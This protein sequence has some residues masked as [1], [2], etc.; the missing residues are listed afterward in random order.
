MAAWPI[1]HRCVVHGIKR[2]KRGF[3]KRNKV[4]REE[5]LVAELRIARRIDRRSAVHELVEIAH[6]PFVVWLAVARVVS[7]QE[8]SRI[9]KPA[10][11]RMGGLLRIPVQV[12]VGR[13]SPRAASTDYQIRRRIEVISCAQAS[14]YL[15]WTMRSVPS[16]H[17]VFCFFCFGFACSIPLH[18]LE[19][20]RSKGEGKRRKERLHFL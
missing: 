7:I 19:G 12:L 17:F 16:I 11:E 15:F 4:V 18:E 2:E 3:D 20:H 8:K 6:A 14:Y 10:R 1:S 9:R 13:E 5:T